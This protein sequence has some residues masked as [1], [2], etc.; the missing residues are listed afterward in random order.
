MIYSR[1]WRYP[2]LGNHHELKSVDHCQYA[3]H[4]RREQ[5]CVNPYHYNRWNWLTT[6]INHQFCFF[7]VDTPSLP[8]VMVPKSQTSINLGT[9]GLQATS[10]TPLPLDT[11]NRCP[12]NNLNTNNN[13]NTTP[14]N[15]NNT[16]LITPPT[17]GYVTDDSNGNGSPQES[18]HYTKMHL[19]N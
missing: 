6:I 16:N 9:G 12:L 1:L 3:F 5:V 14:N 19:W 18:R 7:R 11:S 4:L 15:Y 17:S 10:G 13:A 8:P 2:D